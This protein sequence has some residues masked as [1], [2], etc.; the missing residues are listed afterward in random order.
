MS[1]YFERPSILVEDSNGIHAISSKSLLLKRRIIHLEEDIAG[2]AVNEIIRQLILLGAQ[3]G[4]PVTILIDTNG[5]SIQAGL[6]MI[7]VMEACP[8][9]IRT[10]ALGNACSMGAVILA[11]GTPGH[12]AISSRSK[13]LLHEPLI[14]VGVSG[15]ASRMESI[16]NDLKERR[17]TI[18]RMLAWYTGQDLA[19]VQEATSYN[20][21]FTADEARDFGLVDSV[22]ADADLF[23]V[24]SGGVN[25]A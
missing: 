1:H 23:A 9:I 18:N 24:I 12:R 6:Q 20:H 2:A 16:A 13:V 11:A 15:S 5:G 22:V 25:N 21:W 3:S 8:C 17:E 19:T 4:E 10:I 7:D 14:G